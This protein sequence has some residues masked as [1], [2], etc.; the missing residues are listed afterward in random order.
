M[1]NI[2]CLL[3]IL[4]KGLLKIK[5]EG[6]GIQPS[7]ISKTIKSAGKMNLP[8]FTKTSSSIPLALL[9]LLSANY[10]VIELGCSSPKPSFSYTVYGIKLTPAPRSSNDL[11]QS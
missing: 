7:S 8:T 9:M 2:R 5:C 1:C 6:D 3:V 10:K 4:I 11:S